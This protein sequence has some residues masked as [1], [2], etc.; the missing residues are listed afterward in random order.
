[1]VLKKDDIFSD[2]ADSKVYNH[3]SR[4]QYDFFLYLWF[5]MYT[6]GSQA[7]SFAEP[8]NNCNVFFFSLELNV[9]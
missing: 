7:F 5:T 9:I 3:D 2:V 1:M 6:S 4:P 8:A